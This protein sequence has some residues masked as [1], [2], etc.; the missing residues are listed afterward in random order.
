MRIQIN[1]KQTC[2]F[3]MGRKVE[4]TFLQRTTKRN[5]ERSSIIQFTGAIVRGKHEEL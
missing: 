4:Q 1:S 5:M 3:K 2:K